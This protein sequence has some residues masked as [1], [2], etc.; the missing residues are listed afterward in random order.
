MIVLDLSR[1]GRHK[2]LSD[3]DD[4]VPTSLKRHYTTSDIVFDT[5]CE[6]VCVDMTSAGDIDPGLS[7]VDTKNAA[8]SLADGILP[9]HCW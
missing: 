1:I 8:L 6:E 3:Y 7:L 9:G 5:D 4:M 2:N